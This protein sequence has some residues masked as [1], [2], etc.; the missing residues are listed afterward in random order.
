[1]RADEGQ[2]P[3][4][5]LASDLGEGGAHPLGERR[6]VGD[7][8]LDRIGA[9]DHHAGRGPVAQADRFGPVGEVAV[10]LV[11]RA[12]ER[13]DRGDAGGEQL[14]AVGDQLLGPDLE[15]GTGGLAG[16]AR[17]VRGPA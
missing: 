7:P 1:V 9:V 14:G 10:G 2:A 17:Q 5:L 16:T 11:D 8:L 15:G 4:L 6:R 3:L 13:P 12:G